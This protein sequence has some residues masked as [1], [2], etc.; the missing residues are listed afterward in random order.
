[1][2]K[3]S[4][5]L[6]LAIFFLLS[7]QANAASPRTVLT[8]TLVFDGTTAK[9][10]IFVVGSAPNDTISATL[11]LWQGDICIETW[12]GKS[13]SFLSM[14]ETTTVVKGRTYKLA[15]DISINGVPQATVPVIRTCE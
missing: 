3:R 7:I 12:E 1:M 2:K 15:V 5:L 14:S 8:P 9:C 10:S 4:V 11:K 6:S 13:T